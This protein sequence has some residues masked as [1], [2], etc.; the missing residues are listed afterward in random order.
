MIAETKN[1][2]FKFRFEQ[3]ITT[4]AFNVQADSFS[5]SLQILEETFNWTANN[6]LNIF[7]GETCD[8]CKSM[9]IQKS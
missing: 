5:H 9:I 3:E 7:C 8:E 2:S 4:E 6:M 1:Y